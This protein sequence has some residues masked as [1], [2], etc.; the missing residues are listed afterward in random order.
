MLAS[1]KDVPRII[2]RQLAIL[3]YYLPRALLCFICFFIPVI[4]ALAA[5]FWF[6]FNAWFLTMTY[7]DYPTDNS[8]ISLH[9]ARDWLKARR[10][11]L[12]GFGMGIMVLAM[13]PIINIFVVPA[14][15]AG[16]TKLWIDE[17][18]AR[19]LKPFT[20]KG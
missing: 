16:A 12:L 6:L 3:G 13:V 11:S 4:Q 18:R 1:L 5:F 20:A 14:A 10:F 19:Q 7:I 8:K 2:G 17:N 15:V 9:D